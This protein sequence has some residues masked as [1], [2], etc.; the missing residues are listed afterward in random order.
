[1]EMLLDRGADPNIFNSNGETALTAAID[2]YFPVESLRILLEKGAD[3]NFPDAHGTT[4]LSSAI[5]NGRY[6]LIELLHEYGAT[7]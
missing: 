6:D 2:H 4:A 5:E 3:P 1:M 7:H